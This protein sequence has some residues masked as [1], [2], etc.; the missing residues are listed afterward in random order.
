[1]GNPT[2]Q[3]LVENRREG[4]YVVFD[5]FSGMFTREPGIVQSGAGV[6]ITGLVMAG[7]LTGGA[8]VAAPLGANNGTGGFGAIVVGATARAG[9]YIVEFND[10]TNFVVQDPTGLTIGHGKTG[11]AVTVGG[12]TFTVTAG[13]TAFAAADSFTVT[14]TGTVKYVP[15]DPAL[16]GVPVA[17]LWTGYVD[18]TSADRRCIVN[19]RGPMK[20]N[21]A[22]LI[23][24]P[25]VTTPAHKT[26]ALSL[27]K[28]A[29]I[30]SV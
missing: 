4:G 16:V 24:G 23:W 22:E 10:A 27:L 8:A 7:I 14:V 29:Q 30:L 11:A 15:W 2:F 25:A 18:A 5:P 3:P 6:C 12:L 28:A 20:V 21:I 9:V 13:G 19:V 1:M 17:I 26:L